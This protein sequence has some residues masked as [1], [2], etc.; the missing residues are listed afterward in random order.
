MR[1]ICSSSNP[2]I[3]VRCHRT[4][5]TAFLFSSPLRRSSVLLPRHDIPCI[6]TS[7][8]HGLKKLKDLKCFP[9]SMGLCDGRYTL[10][11]FGI[12]HTHHRQ[13][14]SVFGCR[15]LC[16]VA[17]PLSYKTTLPMLALKKPP[18]PFFKKM[19][20]FSGEV[21]SGRF[22]PTM[23]FIPFHFRPM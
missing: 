11:P 17:M 13:C 23:T 6:R 15:L 5:T 4:R 7:Y 16:I 18:I 1:P 3:S 21:K 22:V 10:V 9:L 8:S 14:A 20:G 19:E 2:R 12:P